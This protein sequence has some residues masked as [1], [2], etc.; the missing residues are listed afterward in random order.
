M[1]YRFQQLIGNRIAEI[2]DSRGRTHRVPIDYPSNYQRGQV[3]KPTLNAC[4]QPVSLPGLTGSSNRVKVFKDM[5][6]P[7]RVGAFQDTDA[8]PVIILTE[9]F[10][11]GVI[12]WTQYV[13][14]SDEDYEFEYD[15]PYYLSIGHGIPVTPQWYLDYIVPG[16]KPQLSPY[17]AKAE[18]FGGR[19]TDTW[20]TG[21]EPR[22]LDFYGS[23]R[24]WIEDIFFRW[25]QRDFIYPD[26]SLGFQDITPPTDP[27]SSMHLTTWYEEINPNWGTTW[28]SGEMLWEDLDL[29][30]LLA[31][32]VQGNANPNLKKLNFQLNNIDWTVINKLSLLVDYIHQ[33][34]F[35]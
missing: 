31:S 33:N 21:W 29:L 14:R 30:G 13:R 19:T 24:F 32:V 12:E 8:V 23:S 9:G 25:Q 15:I 26:I 35:E 34:A 18:L 28:G 5:P 10:L 1:V 22:G 2:T 11:D 7:R 27:V 3:I 17:P 6:Q 20:F 16:E 4:Q